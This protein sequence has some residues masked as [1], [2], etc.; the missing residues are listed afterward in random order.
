MKFGLTNVQMHQGHV[1]HGLGASKRTSP[2]QYR[3]RWPLVLCI[4]FCLAFWAVAFWGATLL[5]R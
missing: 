2:P 1:V 3:V 5:M 4:G